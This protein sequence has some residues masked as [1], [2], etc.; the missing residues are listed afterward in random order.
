MS[1]SVITCGNPDEILSKMK[2]SF[3]DTCKAVEFDWNNRSDYKNKKLLFVIQLEEFGISTETDLML[4]KIISSSKENQLEGSTGAILIRAKEEMYTKT[5]ASL[6]VLRLNSMGMSFMGRPMVEAP[7]NLKNYKTAEK[8]NGLSLE[9]NLLIETKHLGQRFELHKDTHFVGKNKMLVI[10]GSKEGSNTLHLWKES[11]KYISKETKIKEYNLQKGAI[12]DC[13]GCS[14]TICKH[15]ARQKSCYYGDAMVQEVY[16]E[17]LQAQ[18]IV[19]L[20]PNYNDA[21][22]ANI[23]ALINRLSALFRQNRFYEKRIYAIIVSGSSGSEALAMQLIRA[24]NMNKTF[25]L[26]PKF[27]VCAVANDKGSILEVENLKEIAES[28]GKRLIL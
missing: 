20:C 1:I 10:H 24:M 22:T 5:M 16:P 6:L 15:Y 21:L 17:I 2:K 12:E 14:Y 26:P 27:M 28:F 25:Y 13:K 19:L 3:L 4:K 8:I 9:E 7:G 11:K 18:A 23:T